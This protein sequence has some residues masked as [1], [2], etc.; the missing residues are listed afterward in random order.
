[1]RLK[2]QAVEHG[3]NCNDLNEKLIHEINV[4]TLFE[5]RCHARRCQASLGIVNQ[6]LRIEEVRYVVLRV[7]VDISE[8]KSLIH[9]GKGRVGEMD[10]LI[11]PH[12]PGAIAI[13]S[14]SGGCISFTL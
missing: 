2:W 9:H 14:I 11:E 3:G 7:H 10:S 12:N 13:E 4:I 8:A 5:R 6:N 1:M